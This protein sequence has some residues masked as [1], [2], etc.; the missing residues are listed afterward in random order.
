MLTDSRVLDWISDLSCQLQFR[1][2]LSLLTVK[3]GLSF[4]RMSVRPGIKTRD[5]GHQT[6]LMPEKG[7]K[8]PKDGFPSVSVRT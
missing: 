4:M 6:S 5:A 7:G 3:S 2:F 8:H 1:R